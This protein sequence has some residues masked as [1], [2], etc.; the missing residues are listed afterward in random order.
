M[1]EGKLPS[2][3]KIAFFHINSKTFIRRL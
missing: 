1:A 3:L 2:K